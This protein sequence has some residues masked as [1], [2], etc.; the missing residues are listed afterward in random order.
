MGLFWPDSVPPNQLPFMEG[1]R[2]ITYCRVN[3]HV[4]FQAHY[5][6]ALSLPNFQMLLLPARGWNVDGHTDPL[7]VPN[8]GLFDGLYCRCQSHHRL[9]FSDFVGGI[10]FMR[11]AIIHGQQA[12][13]VLFLKPIIAKKRHRGRF[14]IV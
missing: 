1:F 3:R 11:D 4:V 6:G 14:N 2:P 7:P 10:R 5:F 8:I 9:V 13:Q 12:F